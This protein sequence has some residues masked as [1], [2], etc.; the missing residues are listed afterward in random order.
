L[1]AGATDGMTDIQDK[2]TGLM[3]M[4]NIKKVADT[5]YLLL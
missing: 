2:Q 1:Q 5:D 3:T 4:P